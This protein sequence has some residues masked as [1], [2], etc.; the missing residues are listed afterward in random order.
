MS[1]TKDISKFFEKASKKRD[2]SGQPKLAKT[3]KKMREESSTGSLTDMSDNVFAEILKAPE[4]IEILFN[5]LKMR[6]GKQ[7][8][9]AH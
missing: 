4:C 8:I 3:R 9:F 7:R 6:R 1:L 2:L 5:C